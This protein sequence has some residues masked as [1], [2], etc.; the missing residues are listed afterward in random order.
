M[1]RKIS[2][3]IIKD[4]ITFIQTSDE[5]S[6]KISEL[7]LT[8]MPGG[9]NFSHYHKKFTETFTAVEGSL[10]LK[11]GGGKV[12][13]LKPGETYSVLPEQAHSFFNPGEKEIKFNIK[14]TPG[15]QGF[16]NSLRILYGLAEDGLTD[17]KS[18]PRSLTHM[19]IIASLSDSYL[20]G[21]MRLLSPVFNMLVKRARQS[22]LEKEFIDKY[23]N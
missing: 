12:K 15:N 16:E 5:T 4:T 18:I 7:E 11:L 2:N 17:K 13:I 23:C 10:G 9:A 21:I 3:P 19:A 1:K 22:G 14:I 8:L 6:S 20:P